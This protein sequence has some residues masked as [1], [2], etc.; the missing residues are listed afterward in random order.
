MLNLMELNKDN[1]IPAQDEEC[2]AFVFAFIF[3][4]E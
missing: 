1:G 2:F 4:S 3:V